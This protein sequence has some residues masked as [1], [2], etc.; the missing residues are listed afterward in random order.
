MAKGNNKSIRFSVFVFVVL[1]VLVE[2]RLNSKYA[3]SGPPE[4]AKA[5]H[6]ENGLYIPQY[7]EV[8]SPL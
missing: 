5:Q 4:K 2:G 1:V 6:T 7:F 3:R 8:Y